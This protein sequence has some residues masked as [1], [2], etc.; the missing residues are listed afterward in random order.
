M[1]LNFLKKKNVSTAFNLDGWNV[2]RYSCVNNL[3]IL[4]FFFRGEIDAKTKSNY[5]WEAIRFL[6][7]NKFYYCHSVCNKGFTSKQRG[8]KLILV[9][10]S[11][12]LA[13]VNIFLFLSNII[14]NFINLISLKC[15]IC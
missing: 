2:I 13:E 8:L 4:I 3:G 11:I 5:I 14:L 1:A 7:L 12:F 15:H 10:I 6:I 9:I